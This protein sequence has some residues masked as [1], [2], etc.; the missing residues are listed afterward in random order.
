MFTAFIFSGVVYGQSET[1]AV[2]ENFLQTIQKEFSSLQSMAEDEKTHPEKTIK[3]WDFDNTWHAFY[4][5]YY[6]FTYDIKKTDS[7]VTPYIGIV[8]F[9]GKNFEKKR[10]DQGRMSIC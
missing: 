3:Y 5:E 1:E 7:I 10:C 6:D 9:R 8:T 2:K 4:T